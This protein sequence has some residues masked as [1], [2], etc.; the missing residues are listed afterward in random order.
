MIT[1]IISF[2]GRWKDATAIV[3]ERRK[4]V[5]LEQDDSKPKVQVIVKVAKRDKDGRWVYQTFDSFNVIEATPE[6]VSGVVNKAFGR[7]PQ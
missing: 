1:E 3:R 5:R 7:K 4:N 6:E 2:G